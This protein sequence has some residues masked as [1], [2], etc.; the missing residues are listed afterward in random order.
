MEEICYTFHSSR[1]GNGYPGR[2][3]RQAASG[4]AAERRFADGGKIY[5][6]C[7][8]IKGSAPAECREWGVQASLRK[9]IMRAVPCE[10]ADGTGSIAAA[11]RRRAD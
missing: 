8:D 11:G 5:T 7:Q 9:C 6:A 1:Y 10:Q 3:H 4:I 2:R